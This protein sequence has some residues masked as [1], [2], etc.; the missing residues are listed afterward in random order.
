MARTPAGVRTGLT[1]I[2]LLANGNVRVR[3]TG[4]P[5]AVYHVE[6]ATNALAWHEVG[7]SIANPNG[8]LEFLDTEPR[9]SPLK[10]YR[11]RKSQ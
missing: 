9:D 1:S 7:T 5:G 8:D 4:T 2:E 6:T 11:F 3:Q 10:F